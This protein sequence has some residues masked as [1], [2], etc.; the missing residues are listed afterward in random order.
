M[1]GVCTRASPSTA[2][3]TGRAIERACLAEL[4]ALKPGNVSLY[5]DG[6]GMTVADFARSARAAAPVLALPGRSVGERI[7]GAV[8]ATRTVVDCN[9]NLGI[10]LLCA[11]L[12]HAALNARPGQPL[13]S[14]LAETL[15]GLTQQDTV[16][17]YAAIRRARPGG[18]GVVA[19]H[20]VSRVRP[21][22]G[23]RDVMA[24][25]A[26]RDR[27]AR[28]Y[29]ANYADL[30][31]FAEPK[32]RAGV[33]RWRSE[34]W[35]VVSTYLALIA[36]FGDSLVLRKHGARAVDDLRREAARFGAQLDARDDPAT[37]LL[38]LSLF[39][40]ALKAR[41]INPGT[42]AD[43]IVATLLI[44]DLR[45]ITQTTG[46]APVTGEPAESGCRCSPF[47]GTQPE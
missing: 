28:Q 23:L 11:P 19:R 27:I 3:L 9:T 1:N 22:A 12:A 41:H 26:D 4:G 40:R 39:D 29:T 31:E 33:A 18:L 47:H 38:R 34:E 16:H 6:H 5:A 15:D 32:L 37:L 36:E 24:L 25:A 2:E 20:D 10:V 8:A 43:L 17:A 42:S 35:A 13:R 46:H 14:A 7:L 45:A 30:F 44:G 21:R